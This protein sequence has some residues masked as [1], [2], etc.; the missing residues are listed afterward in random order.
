MDDP[1]AEAAREWLTRF[2]DMYA[3]M[4]TLAANDPV[5]AARV[6]AEELL[7][8]GPTGNDPFIVAGMIAEALPGDERAA[9]LAASW[10]ER[11]VQAVQKGRAERKSRATQRA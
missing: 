11:Y 10:S 9:S 5:H 8:A 3:G 7:K 4:D 1:V 6:K 2:V